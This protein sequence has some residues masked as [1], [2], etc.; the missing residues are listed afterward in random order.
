MFTSLAELNNWS[1]NW[2]FPD[3]GLVNAEPVDCFKT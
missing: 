2:K 3:V 1:Q